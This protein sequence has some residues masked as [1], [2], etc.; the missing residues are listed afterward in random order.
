MSGECED[1][2]KGF[3]A[4]GNHGFTSHTPEPRGQTERWLNS[5]QKGG[6]GG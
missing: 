6:D 3:T 2:K 5:E 4:S 1:G